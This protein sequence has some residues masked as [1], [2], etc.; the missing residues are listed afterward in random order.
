M[1]SWYREAI[2]LFEKAGEGASIAAGDAHFA[3]ACDGGSAD[4]TISHARKAAAKFARMHGASAR[5]TVDATFALAQALVERF[6][7]AEAAQKLAVVLPAYVREF[8]K[9]H[10]TLVETRRL[11]ASCLRARDRTEDT[12]PLLRLAHED[13]LVIHGEK[14]AESIAVASEFGRALRDVGQL[15]LAEKLFRGQ[16][17]AW[18]SDP[19]VGCARG[20]GRPALAGARSSPGRV[21][22]G[23]CPDSG[24]LARFRRSLHGLRRS[25]S[26][27]T[28]RNQSIE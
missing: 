25:F 28:C 14:S 1:A 8:A 5:R 21:R 13:S 11:M 10:S 23:A 6:D 9:P 20:G 24:R 16:L 22:S 7:H 2:G 26:P 12:V 3:L 18:S 17:A 4:A 27:V 15:Q 19:D